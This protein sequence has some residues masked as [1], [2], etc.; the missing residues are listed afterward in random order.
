MRDPQKRLFWALFCAVLAFSGS[1][2][3]ADCEERLYHQITKATLRLF[4][5]KILALSD[6]EAMANSEAP[7]NPLARNTPVARNSA[8]IHFYQTVLGESVRAEWP[9]IRNELLGELKK[10]EENAHVEHDA[11]KKNRSRC[12]DQAHAQI[13]DGGNGG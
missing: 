5:N 2:V 4:E 6:V 8:A 12:S 1:G 11:H 10:L 3:F 9:R 7:I 13:G